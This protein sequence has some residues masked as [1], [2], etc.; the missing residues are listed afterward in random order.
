MAAYSDSPAVGIS[1]DG[2]EKLDSELYVVAVAECFAVHLA[3]VH[4]ANGPSCS[5]KTPEH[6]L[7]TLKQVVVGYFPVQGSVLCPADC[8][9]CSGV[10]CVALG[11]H[12]T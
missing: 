10:Q 5:L 4:S 11:H 7:Q 3:D 1:E 8:G 12:Q 6:H 2:N 9:M